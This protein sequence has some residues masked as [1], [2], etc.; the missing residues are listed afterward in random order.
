MCSET[1]S[2]QEIEPK[3]ISYLFHYSFTS[4]YNLGDPIH[5]QEPTMLNAL[6]TPVRKTVISI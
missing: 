6:K 5:V 2:E 4:R 1:A 3:G